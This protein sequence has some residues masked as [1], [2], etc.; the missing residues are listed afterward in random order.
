MAAFKSLVVQSEVVRAGRLRDCHHD[1]KNHKM[2]KGDVCLEIT[3][4]MKPR[5]YCVTCA[6]RMID[7]SIKKLEG[8][9]HALHTG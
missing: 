8:L 4:Q 5:G 7:D 1:R 3:Q 2:H 9:K 6:T